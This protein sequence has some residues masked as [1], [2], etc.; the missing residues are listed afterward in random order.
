MK[1]ISFLILMLLGI[2]FM[3]A[4]CETKEAYHTSILTDKETETSAIPV[5]EFQKAEDEEDSY[6]VLEETLEIPD[7]W[8]D[9]DISANDQSIF[10]IA[11]EYQPMGN[12]M[13]KARIMKYDMESES[14]S[15][16]FEHENDAGFYLNELEATSEYLFWVHTENENKKIECLNLAEGEI[17]V[18]A[19][20]PFNDAILLQSDENFLTWYEGTGE[21]AALWAYNINNRKT[22]LVSDQI[23]R[24]HSYTRAQINHGITWFVSQQSGQKWV[25]IYDLNQKKELEKI[26]MEADMTIFQ[27]SA[28]EQF[29]LYSILPQ[30]RMD[31]RIF[32][33]DYVNENL[34]LANTHDDAYVF[35]FHYFDKKIFINERNTNSIVIR[36]IEHMTEQ[37]FMDEQDHVY[38]LASK[39]AGDGYVALDSLDWEHPRILYLSKK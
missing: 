29:F 12:S 11:A 16:C 18:V 6:S 2:C 9:G 39:T 35:S 30:D 7:G 19:E 22:F 32:V 1:K 8:A 10:Y 21:A 25:H 31:Y 38:I 14:T 27:A 13:L 20:T 26:Q 4:G 37:A 5:M 17:S 36:D 3:M 15:V 24:G 28:D 33:Y 34:F 23:V